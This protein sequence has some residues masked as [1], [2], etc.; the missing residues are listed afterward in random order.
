MRTDLSLIVIVL[1]GVTAACSGQTP[2]VPA[3]P[4]DGIDSTFMKA[5]TAQTVVVKATNP[6]FVEVFGS[7]LLLYLHGKDPIKVRVLTEPYHH[8]KDVAHVPFTVYL[9]LS[10]QLDTPLSDD[11]L[12]P[13]RDFQTKLSA[14]L[15]VLSTEGFTPD[16]LVRQ[17][18]ILDTS[19][20]F[21]N[22]ILDYKRVS[23]DALRTYARSMAPLMLENANEAGCFQVEATHKQMLAWKPLFTSAEEWQQLRV[24]IKN[25]HQARYRDAATQYFAWLLGGTSPTWGYP[26]ETSRVVYAEALLGKDDA[27]DELVDILVDFE[28]SRAFFGDDWRMSE[29]ILSNGA[30]RCIASLPSAE[31]EWHPAQGSGR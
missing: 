28:A 16:Q 21:V 14:A 30:A 6:P 17:Q 22:K 25:S 4:L 23:A 1:C 3:N 13:L 26:G 5:Y 7:S 10:N 12:D 19:L 20:R 2:Q 18:A 8:L 29:D 27:G 9:L 15:P 11:Q 31:R 24:V